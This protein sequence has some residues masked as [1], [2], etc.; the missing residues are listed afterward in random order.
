M[1]SKETDS[2]IDKLTNISGPEFTNVS[3]EGGPKQKKIPR[4]I[5]HFSDGVLE[6]YS[7]D[8]EEEKLPE[9]PSVDPKTLK[10]VPWFWHYIVVS[11][12]TALGA[13][14]FCG[15]KLAWFFGITSP[16]YQHAIDEYYRLKDEEENEKKTRG[17]KYEE[18]NSQLS[19]IN[20]D[21]DISMTP[22]PVST[23]GPNK[24]EYEKY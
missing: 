21:N 14:D 5:I 4:R 13:A 2:Q 10:W 24:D 1:A 19:S 3:L 8:E 20:V 18:K 17:E 22:F 7:T 11:A 12:V 15:E 16:K 23:S 6:E 9:K